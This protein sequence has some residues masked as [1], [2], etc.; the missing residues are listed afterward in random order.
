MLFIGF[1]LSFS[2]GSPSA[3]TIYSPNDL[4]SSMGYPALDH[5]SIPEV[6]EAIHRV[7]LAAKSAG[8]WAGMFCTSAEQVKARFEEG[9]ESSFFQY[10]CDT[11]V[12]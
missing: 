6:Q 12:L 10:R 9:C 1:V 4:S 5:A 3:L 2:R 8:K 11:Y 7:L